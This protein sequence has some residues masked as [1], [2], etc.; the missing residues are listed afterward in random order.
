MGKYKPGDLVRIKDGVHEEGMGD[1]RFAL[2]LSEWSATGTNVDPKRK[3][4]SIYN[5]KMLN[6][7][8]M[9]IHE[10]FLERMNV[11]EEE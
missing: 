6:G 4:T 3:F 9:K 1:K 2:V 10:M 8:R 11:Q 7:H 5:V